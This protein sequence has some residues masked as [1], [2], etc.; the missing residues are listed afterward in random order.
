[1]K[2]K[3]ILLKN[4]TSPAN[5]DL[6]IFP[7]PSKPPRPPRPAPP[8]PTL[9]L[10]L[11]TKARFFYKQPQAVPGKKI[12]EKLSNTL[13]LNFWFLKI[14]P[15][16]HPR[17][18]PKKTRDI[19]K[20]YQKNKYVSFNELVWLMAM[21]MRLKMKNRS[22]LYNI[23]RPRQRQGHKC[24]KYKKCLGIIMVI[25]IK[26]HLSNIWRSIQETVSKHWG[27]FEK[28]CCL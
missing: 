16:L 17:Y 18:H 12:K 23:N 10:Q 8:T 28:T 27:W 24:T 7:G 13:T 11:G 5:Y 1:M 22:R 15:F 21:K 14:I 9:P 19:L 20:V 6:V 4:Q 25:C 2:I 26:Q 3:Q